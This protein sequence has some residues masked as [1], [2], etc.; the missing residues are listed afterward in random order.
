MMLNNIPNALTIMRL[1]LIAPFLIFLYQQCY[2]QAFYVFILAGFTDALDGWL[3]RSFHWQSTFGSLADPIA[4]KL[5]ITSSFIALALI[6]QLPWWL[7][8]LVF[9]RDLTI[10]FGALA[11][12]WF[13]GR[14]IVFT[15]TYLSK[16]NTVLQLALVTLCL[17]DLAFSMTSP[18][19]H[20]IFLILTAL[21]T[22]CSYAQYVWVWGR[23]ACSINRV[24]K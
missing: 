23:K 15:P 3:A 12:Y 6:G 1:F 22:S 9:L 5:L 8:L 14:K 10:S 2:V 7:C 21:T 17:F 11:W 18:D 16:I 20:N 19:L 13:I 24:K 4:D